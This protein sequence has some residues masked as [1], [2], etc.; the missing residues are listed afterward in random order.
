MTEINRAKL[1]AVEVKYPK[2]REVMTEFDRFKLVVEKIELAD[3]IQ[4]YNRYTLQ[5]IAV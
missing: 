5:W 1:I 4:A 3:V 2:V